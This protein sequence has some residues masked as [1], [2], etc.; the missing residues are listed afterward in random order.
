MQEQAG[1]QTAIVVDDDPMIRA[2]LRS[3]LTSIGL[4]VQLACHGY[5]AVGLAARSQAM[6][7]LL[8]LAMPGLDGVAAC[9]RIRALPGYAAIPIVVLTAKLDPQVTA[10]AIAAGATLVLSKP[11]QPA[12]LLQALLPYCRISPVARH[13]VARGATAARTIAAPRAPGTDQRTWR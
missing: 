3:A 13:A 1:K 9:T 4:D 10:A 7:I 12:A 8:D 11:F 6:L 2:V 5:E